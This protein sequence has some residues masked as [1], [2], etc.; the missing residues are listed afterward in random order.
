MSY[1]NFYKT[2]KKVRHII[3]KS[4]LNDNL[5]NLY[6]YDFNVASDSINLFFIKILFWKFK[7]T[8]KNFFN[9]NDDYQNLNP[10]NYGV[11]TLYVSN[12]CMKN[13]NLSN[14]TIWN[15][16]SIQSN[17]W[18]NQDK[19]SNLIKE[20]Y[21]A[22]KKEFKE[23]NQLTAIHPGNNLLS[24][25]NGQWSSITLIGSK[26]TNNELIKKFPTTFELLNK[27]P[28]CSNF[29]FVAFSKLSAGTT[30]KAHTGSS[31]LRLRY[32]LGIEVPEPEKVK[33]R[34][35]NEWK[36]WKEGEVLVF[37]DSFEHEVYHKGT[38]DRVVLMIDL[39]HPSINKSECKILSNSIFFN[40]G[41]KT[42]F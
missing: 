23:N 26:G 9:T 11:T 12:I 20:N 3:Q 2:I 37:D 29:G 31:N 32:H 14:P 19:F 28:I 13:R 10:K 30:I 39:W 15:C 41:K 38:K 22:I 18:H 6:W 21:L 36:S 27:L 4:K 34:V 33:I 1:I 40:Y 17:P 8:C 24:S 7:R 16:K 35:G 42:N 25:K 5:N